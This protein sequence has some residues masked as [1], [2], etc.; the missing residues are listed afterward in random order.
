MSMEGAIVMVLNALKKAMEEEL[1][2]KAIEIGVVKSTEN[3]RRIEEKEI[4][5][6]A[7]KVT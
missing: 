7:V 6:Y 3:F 2:V 4:E 1:N 5:K